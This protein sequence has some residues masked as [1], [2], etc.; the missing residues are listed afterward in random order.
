MCIHAPVFLVNIPKHKGE[1]STF[2]SQLLP[3]EKWT[4]VIKHIPF[5]DIT[6]CYVILDWKVF[7]DSLCHYLFSYF[8]DV[9][10]NF[11]ILLLKQGIL[12]FEFLGVIYKH[13]V[14]Q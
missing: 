1:N 9:K 12:V 14:Q 7:L 4:L 3:F 2:L 10:I 6:E 13:H 8:A 5:W 11:A